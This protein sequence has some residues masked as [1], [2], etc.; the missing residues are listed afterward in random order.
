MVSI[1]IAGFVLAAGVAACGQQVDLN[2]E[3]KSG[4]TEKQGALLTPP[5][6]PAANLTPERRGDIFMARKMF[7][8]AVEMYKQ[9]PQD[10]A[11]IW[12][13]MGI[14]YHQMLQLD[15]AKKNY[16]KALKINPKYSEA[17]NNLGTVYYARKSYRRAIS[18]Y[19]RALRLAPKSASIYSNLGTAHFARK[20]YKE[21]FECYQTALSL[22]PEVFEHRGTYGVMLQERTV[23]ERAKFHYFLAKT[24]AKAGEFDRA[25]NYLRKAFEEGF[26][27]RQK[28]MEDPE[29]EK[30]R[31]TAEF[32]DL[33]KLEPKVL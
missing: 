21:A 17:L 3:A 5:A 14:A 20:K 13:K 7:R 28:V 12:N 4:A 30:L 19:K 1:R 29:F 6:P 22:D 18:Y 8:E 2:P 15:T 23:E 10:S 25:I 9:A 31:Q 33:M 11:V 32:Q 27:E 26:K 16:E 24:Y